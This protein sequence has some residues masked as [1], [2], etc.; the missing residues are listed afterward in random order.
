MN[1]GKRIEVRRQQTLRRL[2]ELEAAA[3][4]GGGAELAWHI[5]QALRSG[6]SLPEIKA[7]LEQGME[8]RGKTNRVVTRCP[9][10]LMDEPIAALS[11][12]AGQSVI[13]IAS[14]C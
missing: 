1:T 11:R 10:R 5:M 14:S 3:R 9:H 13:E 6:A 8:M 4:L 2:S 12:P 7:A